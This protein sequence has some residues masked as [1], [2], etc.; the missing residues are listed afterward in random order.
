MVYERHRVL[1][2]VTRKVRDKLK[3]NDS[4]QFNVNFDW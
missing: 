2:K 1:V 4:Q 3:F